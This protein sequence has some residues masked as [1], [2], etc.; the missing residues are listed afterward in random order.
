MRPEAG[1]S[2]STRRR[3]RGA[4]S[5]VGSCACLKHRPHHCRGRKEFNFSPFLP[6]ESLP[7]PPAAHGGHSLGARAAPGARKWSWHCLLAGGRTRDPRAEPALP[8]E[9]R[10]R[11]TLA[12]PSAAL[13]DVGW[14]REKQIPRCRR[15][16][17]EGWKCAGQMWGTGLSSGLGQGGRGSCPRQDLVGMFLWI[18][19]EVSSRGCDFLVGGGKQ[20]NSNLKSS[21]SFPL[22]S[23]WTGL[24]GIFSHQPPACGVDPEHPSGRGYSGCLEPSPCS[25]CTR[26]PHPS[27]AKAGSFPV[28]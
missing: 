23:L 10:H 7:K 14:E 28:S 5:G 19:Q 24:P 2:A 25:S 4:A 20:N 3:R 26:C 18:A 13:P 17:A 9:R 12:L 15:G 27:L 22:S 8:G 1:G 21:G 6:P 16:L 11:S